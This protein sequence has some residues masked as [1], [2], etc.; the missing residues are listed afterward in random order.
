MGKEMIKKGGRPPA[1]ITNDRVI[2]VIRMYYRG[3]WHLGSIMGTLGVSQPT[4]SNLRK[5]AL[6]AIQVARGED[7]GIYENKYILNCRL[8]HLFD[9]SY[10]VVEKYDLINPSFT[11]VNPKHDLVKLKYMNL[12]LSIIRYSGELNGHTGGSPKNQLNFVAIEKMLMNV[13]KTNGKD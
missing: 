7:N 2:Q 8:D 1:E 4:A 9:Q 3:N 5:K 10:K 6:E 13:I 11:T 12:I